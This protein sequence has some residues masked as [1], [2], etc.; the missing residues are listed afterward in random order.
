MIRTFASVEAVDPGLRPDGVLSFEVS[1]PDA[2]YPD[3]AAHAAFARELTAR[4]AALPGVA[5]VGAVS[6]L[7]LD[8]YS[9][10]YSPY[11]PTDDE[12]QRDLMADHRAATPDYLRAVG[13]TLVRGRFF[14]A[15]DEA[16]GR[17]VVVVDERLAAEA[18]PG[19]D[20]I[21]KT[22]DCEHQV[23]GRFAPRTVEVVGV[24]KHI[25][26]LELTRQVRGQVYIPYARSPREHLSFVVRGAGDP[27]LR[28]GDVRRIV[29]ALDGQLAV[30]K[31]R[32]LAAYVERALRPA[33]FTMVLAT[34]FGGLALALA[35]IGLYGV[36]A[37]SVSQRRR[38]LGIRLAL[39]AVP[40]DL[41]RQV[42]GEGLT[43]ALAGLALGLLGAALSGRLLGKLLFGVGAGDPATYLA[44]ALILPAAA[45]AAAWLP[46]RRA[47]REDPISVL[48]V[49]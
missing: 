14:T 44:A 18:W 42:V 6:H 19:V 31:V 35:A 5:A 27:L 20:P 12:R 49:D 26:Q 1:I 30:A 33:R 24:V 40:R 13:A 46:A 34:L 16:A 23:E 39:G 8:D 32:P 9:N 17:A 25:H 47:G 29:A 7:P 37:S 41:V 21:G 38:E 45:V 43:L 2:R 3:D 36:I 28:V 22:L 4:L 15:D 10:W 48:R 11:S